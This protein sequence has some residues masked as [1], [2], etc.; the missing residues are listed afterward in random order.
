M[1]DVD[2]RAGELMLR[3]RMSR[4]T[5]TELALYEAYDPAGPPMFACGCRDRQHADCAAVRSGD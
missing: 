4:H 5:A 3:Q 1:T 2:R